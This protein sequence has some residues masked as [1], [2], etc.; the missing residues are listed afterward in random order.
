[1]TTQPSPTQR[2]H[3]ATN[4]VGGPPGILIHSA[5]VKTERGALLFLGHSKAG[6]STICNLL[7]DRYETIGDDMAHVE[8]RDG[9]GWVVGTLSSYM[10]QRDSTHARTHRSIPPTTPIF[11]IMRIYQNP[12]IEATPMPPSKLCFHLTN[13]IVEGVGQSPSHSVFSALRWFHVIARMGREIQG[14][15]LQFPKNHETLPYIASWLWS[16]DLQNLGKGR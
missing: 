10:D 11:A 16:T 12:R 5:A 15:H 13:A 8:Y 1:M 9:V 3:A 6:K 14:W 7:S 2:T 4:D